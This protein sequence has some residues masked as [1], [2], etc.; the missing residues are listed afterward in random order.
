M[1]NS[2]QQLWVKAVPDVPVQTVYVD[3]V[4]NL[5]GVKR[6]GSGCARC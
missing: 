4:A 5:V 1:L 2:V 6:I 3:G